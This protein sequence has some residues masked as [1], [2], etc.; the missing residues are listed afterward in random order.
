MNEYCDIY[1]LSQ[2]VSSATRFPDGAIGQPALIEIFLTSSPRD[3]HKTETVIAHPNFSTISDWSVITDAVASI[4]WDYLYHITNPSS[5]CTYLNDCIQT[6]ISDLVPLKHHRPPGNNN[7][8]YVT[9][10][11]IHLRTLKQT[12]WN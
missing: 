3:L 10:E 9:P 4:D 7:L 11:F 6:I 5:A 12:A 2:I 1:A 8:P